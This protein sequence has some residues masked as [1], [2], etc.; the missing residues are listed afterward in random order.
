MICGAVLQRVVRICR[1]C[2]GSTL[3]VWAKRQAL[4]VALALALLGAALTL[5]SLYGLALH[6][7]AAGALVAIMGTSRKAQFATAAAL[8]PAY[9]HA[10]TEPTEPQR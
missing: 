9:T 10:H 3:N 2:S 8:A 5:V 7:L 6:I 1:A 4:R